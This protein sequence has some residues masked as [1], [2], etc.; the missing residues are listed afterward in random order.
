MVLNCEKSNKR[1]VVVINIRH[2]EHLLR[3]KTALMDV[4]NSLDAGI[5]NDFL[6]MELKHACPAVPYSRALSKITGEEIPPTPLASADAYSR[7]I[8]GEYL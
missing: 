8:V 2:Y 5:T 1:N 3:A 7:G 6:A 4:Q